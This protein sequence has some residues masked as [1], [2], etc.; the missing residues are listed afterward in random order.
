MNNFIALPSAVDK[1]R[2]VR[3]LSPGLLWARL[4]GRRLFL[5]AF[6]LRPHPLEDGVRHVFRKISRQL[7][8]NFV[9][10]RRAA[11]ALKYRSMIVASSSCLFLPVIAIRSMLV[12]YRHEPEK[13]LVWQKSSF[14]SPSAC[15]CCQVGVRKAPCAEPH[16]PSA[17]Q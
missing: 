4:S 16:S 9:D 12:G 8:H 13:N 17:S 5:K 6:R 14:G 15:Q 11:V 7:L 10:F 3:K 2:V 1:W